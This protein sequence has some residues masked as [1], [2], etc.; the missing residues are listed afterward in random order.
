MLGNYEEFKKAV[1]QLIK[2]DL[3]SYKERQMKRRID[4]LITKNNVKTYSDYVKSIKTDKEKLEEFVN[5]LT[6]NVSEFYRN[7]DQWK[8]LE[9][10]VFPELIKNNGKSLKIWSAACSTGEEPYSLVMCL[11]KL[12]PLNNI[13]IIATDIDKQVIEKA[14]LGLYNEKNI[15]A[16]PDEFVKKYFTRINDKTVQISS[17]IKKHVEFKQHDLLKDPYPKDCDIIIC[18]NVMIYF[19]EEAKRLI[20]ERFNTSLKKE[21]YLFVG[22][23]EQ[24]IQAHELGFK[25]HKS[26]FYRK[27]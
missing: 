1:F 10:E 19:T 20:Y 12:M 5:Y 7:P 13:K 9:Q 8:V 17:E 21:S 14:R 23:T 4:A 15:K 16:L 22:S 3:N 27:I 2:L 11:S 18:R 24:I 26:F 6:I 25:S